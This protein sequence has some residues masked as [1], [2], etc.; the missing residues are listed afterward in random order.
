MVVRPSVFRKGLK[1]GKPE[2]EEDNSKE[3]DSFFGKLSIQII[4][5]YAFLIFMNC[6]HTHEA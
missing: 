5:I 6:R 3:W 1:K 2:S 4:K